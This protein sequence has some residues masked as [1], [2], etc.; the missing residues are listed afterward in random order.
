M[1]LRSGAAAAAPDAVHGAVEYRQPPLG[2]THQALELLLFRRPAGP[3]QR[4]R[5]RVEGEV[6]QAVLGVAAALDAGLRRDLVDGHR[7]RRP[8]VELRRLRRRVP[9]DL[10]GEPRR[11][12]IADSP[13]QAS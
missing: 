3:V 8:V 9:G 7:V 13:V 5:R 1:G 12:P 11:R 10:L 6:L 4:P 2:V